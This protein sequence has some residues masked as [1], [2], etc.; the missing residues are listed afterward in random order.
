M[1]KYYDTKDNNTPTIHVDPEDDCFQCMKIKKCKCALHRAILQDV[2][3]LNS[4]SIR[5]ADCPDIKRRVNKNNIV[6]FKAKE[7]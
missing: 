7:E 5:V 3:S 6:Q 4:E 2:V 1:Y